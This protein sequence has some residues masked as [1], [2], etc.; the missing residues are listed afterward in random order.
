MME[1]SSPPLPKRALHESYKDKVRIPKIPR[2]FAAARHSLPDLD[3]KIALEEDTR[4][5]LFH[6]TPGRLS[7]HKR[8]GSERSL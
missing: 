2:D 7:P 3:A 5:L 1:I 6:R 8:D 4:R